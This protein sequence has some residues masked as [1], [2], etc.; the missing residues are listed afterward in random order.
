[1]DA[2]W[3]FFEEMD[4]IVFVSDMETVNGG[5]LAEIVYRVLYAFSVGVVTVFFQSSEIGSFVVDDHFHSL[6]L[7]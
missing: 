3:T 5:V 6:F 4:E 7:A 1:M 2:M